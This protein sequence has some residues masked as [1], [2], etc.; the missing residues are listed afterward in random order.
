[1]PITKVQFFNKLEYLIFVLS[2][3]NHPESQVIVK[4]IK[5]SIIEDD[6]EFQ[7]WILEELNNAPTIK[8]VSRHLSGD[9]ALTQ[10]PQLQPDIVIVDLTLKKS[11]IDGIE[12]MFRLKLVLPKIKFLVISA[13]SDEGKIFEALRVGAGAYLQKEDIPR[14][15][16]ELIFEFHKGGAPMSP[17]IAQRIIKSFHQPA[18]ELVLLKE[19]TFR[20]K[21]ILDH[22][23]NGYLYKEIADNLDIKEGTVKQHAHNIYQKLQVNNRTE[24]IRKYLNQ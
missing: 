21:E 20:E 18:N 7:E 9:E 19:L 6:L 13:H 10:I 5:V 15:L 11:K 14:Q 16:T 17:G 2:K 23:S 12:C 4:Y 24:A 8:C 22:L 3:L 1:M